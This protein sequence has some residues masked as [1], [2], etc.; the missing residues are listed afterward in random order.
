MGRN[1]VRA[2]SASSALVR[3]ESFHGTECNAIAGG[4]LTIEPLRTVWV[5]SPG[6]VTTLDQTVTRSMIVDTYLSA[7]RCD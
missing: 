3:D 1:A 2:Q 5:I 6:T 7:V 4:S